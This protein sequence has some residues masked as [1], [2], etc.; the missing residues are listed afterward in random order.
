MTKLKITAPVVGFR[1]DLAGLVFRDGSAIADDSVDR[2]AVAYCR[3]RGYTVEP[4]DGAI[5]AGQVA[6]DREMPDHTPSADDESAA[7]ERPKDY[8]SKAEWV[9][10]AVA[11]GADEADAESATKA[12]L[13][14]LYG[15]NEEGLSK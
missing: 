11:Q 12:D 14:A 15:S 1:G 2:A 3:R 9:A 5:V 13:M 10:Y 4:V 7:V 8:A 6:D